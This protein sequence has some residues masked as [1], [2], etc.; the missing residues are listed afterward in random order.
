MPIKELTKNNKTKIIT[1]RFAAN[2]QMVNTL[3]LLQKKFVM[4]DRT[5]ILKLAIS[6]LANECLD[7]RFDSFDDAMDFW[8]D[9]KDELR[10]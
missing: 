4:L 9:N 6:N 8:K 5:E 10:K 1:Y 2:T 7:N 3:D